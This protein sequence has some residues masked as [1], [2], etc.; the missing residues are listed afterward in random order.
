MALPPFGY[1]P[2]RW[3]ETMPKFA[4]SVLV[5]SLVLT[6]SACA[7]KEKTT[8]K[9]VETKPTATVPTE[10]APAPVEPSSNS[11]DSQTTAS[12]ATVNT[13][14]NKDATETKILSEEEEEKEPDCE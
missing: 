13:T 5:M 11:T 6:L 1:R 4:S 3:F 2:K 7:D 9:P 14:Q 10:V 8:D 12:T